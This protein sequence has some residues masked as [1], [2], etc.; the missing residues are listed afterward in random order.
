MSIV[1]TLASVGHAV[2][3]MVSP[4]VWEG[5]FGA[6]T[7]VLSLIYHALQNSQLTVYAFSLPS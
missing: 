7:L 2:M 5:I 3:V 6:V 1:A 4:G